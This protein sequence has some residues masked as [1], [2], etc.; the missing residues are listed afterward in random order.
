[1]FMLFSELDSVGEPEA[2]S[3]N[4]WRNTRHNTGGDPKLTYKP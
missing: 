2:K 4:T 3:Q 1:M